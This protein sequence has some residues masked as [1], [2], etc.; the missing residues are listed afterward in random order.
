[1]TK[2]VGFVGLGVMGAPMARNLVMGGHEV[3]GYDLSPEAMRA[4]GNRPARSAAEA[5]Q[6]AD[7]VIT[8][9]PKGAHVKDALFGPEG[10]LSTL[11]EGALVIDMST[12]LP[13]ET[14]EIA[15][16]VRES[17]RRFVDAPVGR[18]S[19]HA[20][21]GKLLI[22]VGAEVAD[23]EEAR[24]LL[25]LMG[26]T[27]IHCGKPGAGSRAKIVNNYMSI[28]SNVVTAE[29]LILAERTGLGREIAIEVCRG[30][31]AGQGHL[32]T[33]YPAK[34][35]QGDTTPGFMCDLA[36]KDLAIALELAARVGA[37]VTTGAA[38]KPA[39]DLARATDRGRDDWTAILEVLSEVDPT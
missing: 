1:M 39:Y 15:A 12:V 2:K 16:R 17:G 14:D 34:V 7:A 35:L 36:R 33:T 3:W 31:T 22:M 5:A 11:P 18:T 24:V 29:S 28:V 27:I 26:D 30:T 4:S 25:S 21:E 37:P 20:E 38:A 6:G 13:L 23:L 19:R 10:A 9:L 32:N 8:M